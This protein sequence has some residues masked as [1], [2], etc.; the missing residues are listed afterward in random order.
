M[1][2][3][4]SVKDKTRV[5]TLALGCAAVHFTSQIHLISDDPQPYEASAQE[6]ACRTQRL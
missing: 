5:L 1:D 2:K 6:Q 3:V 4:G